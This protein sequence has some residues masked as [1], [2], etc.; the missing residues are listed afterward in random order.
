M[1]ALYD[2]VAVNDVP[3]YHVGVCF[4]RVRDELD[5]QYDIFSPPARQEAEKSLQRTIVSIKKKYGSKGIFK[6]MN[7]LAGAK[8]LERNTQVGGHRAG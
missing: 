6:G 2:R 8:T 1:A 7:L 4:N 5:W 3:V